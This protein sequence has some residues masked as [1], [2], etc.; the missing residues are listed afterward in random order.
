[1]RKFALSTSHEDCK[2]TDLTGGKGSSLAVLTSI[3]KQFDSVSCP[4]TESIKRHL[5]FRDHLTDCSLQFT[6]PRAIVL[7]TTAYEKFSKVREVQGAIRDLCDSVRR[8]PKSEQLKAACEACVRTVE[9]S[10]IPDEIV[11]EL[12]KE[13][14]A[15][16]DFTDVR[17][18]VRSSAVGEDSEEMS[19]AGQMMTFLGVRG[20]DFERIVS[21]I[22]K[23]WASQFSFTAVNYKRQYGQVIASKM[24]VVVQEMVSSQTSGVMFTCDPVTSSAE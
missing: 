7:T 1:M 5:S 21:S 23:C 4:P 12:R 13:M 9:S 14:A 18:A 2:R 11:S 10:R 20:S 16:G 24:A 3:S 6:V 22:A 8:N 19:A 17:F 15:L